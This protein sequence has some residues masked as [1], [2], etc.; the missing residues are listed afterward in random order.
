[1]KGADG[2]PLRIIPRIAAG[3]YMT[4]GMCL[5]Q[6]ENGV[7]VDV[8]KKTHA[9]DGPVGITDAIIQK[10]LTSGAAPTRTY[11]HLIE[12]LKQSEL[13]ALAEDI[14]NTTF[15]SDEGIYVSIVP[16]RILKNTYSLWTLSMHAHQFR[17]LHMQLVPRL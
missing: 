11:Q 6:D 3:D 7:D 4:F 14:A 16:T 9:H 2:N 5:L 17:V 10:W 12:C 15:S 1:M 13:G 8:L